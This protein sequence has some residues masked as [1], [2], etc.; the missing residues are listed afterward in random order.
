MKQ[1]DK[2]IVLAEVLLKES[3]PVKITKV[4]EFLAREGADVSSVGSVSV[5]IRCDQPTFERLF[6]T[7]IRK[8]SLPSIPESSRRDFGPLKHSAF[9]LEKQIV[10]PE[11][12]AE[13]VEGVY[14]QVP[15]RLL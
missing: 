3:A 6:K 5:S 2:E 1:N 4:A 8:T 10:I 13:D 11:E 7:Q 15:P 9:E 14:I 12:I